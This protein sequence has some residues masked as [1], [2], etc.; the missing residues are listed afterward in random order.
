MRITIES[1]KQDLFLATLASAP[2]L[3]ESV[4][5]GAA[6]TSAHFT[7]LVARQPAAVTLNAGGAPS[8]HMLMRRKMQQLD[9]N[10]TVVSGGLAVSLGEGA[11][12]IADVQALL[13]QDAGSAPKIDP[14]ASTDGN[15]AIKRMQSP[16]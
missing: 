6:P 16:S 7:A 13:H 3:K 14:Q 9:V 11:A 5:V 4:A 12:D 1:D 15:Y 2:L 8:I 10:A